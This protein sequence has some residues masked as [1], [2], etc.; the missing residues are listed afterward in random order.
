MFST[1]MHPI[2]KLSDVVDLKRRTK[3]IVAY[4]DRFEKEKNKCFGLLF[5]VPFYPFP[6]HLLSI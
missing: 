2:F 4:D 6:P 1:N 5:V 3:E